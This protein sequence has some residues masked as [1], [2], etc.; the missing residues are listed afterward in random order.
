M[1]GIAAIAAVA[2]LGET[3]TLKL[4]VASIAIL[5]GIALVLWRRQE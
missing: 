5:S 1:P 3:I 2:L 4:V